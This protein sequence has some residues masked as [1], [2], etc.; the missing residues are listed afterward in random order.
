VTHGHFDH[1]GGG[2]YLQKE[3]GCQILMSK[4]DAE[5]MVNKPMLPEQF[6]PIGIPR[7]DEYIEDGT[8][9]TVGDT[10]FSVYGT[11]GH[12]P[13]GIS[14]TFPVYDNGATHTLCLWGGM[15]MPRVLEDQRVFLESANY[16]LDVCA[17]K[18]ADVEFSTHPF[19]DYTAEKMEV[20]AKK[21][22]DDPNPFVIGEKKVELFMR[23]MILSI[24]HHIAKL[25][26]GA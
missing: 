22:P 21:G 17:K 3:Y 2:E 14:L 1:F 5:F 8:I 13:G 16:F 11:P 15:G 4:T 20:L 9:I 24:E 19:T 10:A 23:C 25:Q 26:N 12:T 7:V 18:S 6:M